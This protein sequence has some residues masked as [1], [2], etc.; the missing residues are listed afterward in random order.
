M[1]EAM[2]RDSRSNAG[3][4]STSRE[5][6]S[7]GREHL[8]STSEQESRQEGV[9]DESVVLDSRVLWK[10]RGKAKI[11]FCVLVLSQLYGEMCIR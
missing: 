11:F 3:L 6:K 4:V 8:G 7:P 2:T 9:S 5:Q 1:C 10:Q